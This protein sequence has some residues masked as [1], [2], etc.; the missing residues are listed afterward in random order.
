[1]QSYDEN[2]ALHLHSL[3]R[4]LSILQPEGVA[5]ALQGLANLFP[6]PEGGDPKDPQN[7]EKAVHLLQEAKRAETD[8]LQ[9]L[10]HL[11]EAFKNL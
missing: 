10:K 9:A 8:G 6:F 11:R 5:A 7:I 4:G 2:Y 1:M 3:K